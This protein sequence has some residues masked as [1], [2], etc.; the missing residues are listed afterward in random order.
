MAEVE[1]AQ[2]VR[3]AA[4][5]SGVW[6]TRN[7]V[8]ALQ[9]KAGRLV[10]YGL[11]NESAAQNKRMKSADDIGI[12]PVLIT[13]AHV[14]QTL[15]QFV[16]VEAK[17]SGWRYSGADREPAQLAWAKHVERLGGRALIVTS[18]E[19]WQRAGI[20]GHRP[21]QLPAPSVS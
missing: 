4:D 8:G 21:C 7:N 11:A 20:V 14:G 9:D 13:P 1:V 3:L 16:S 2:R 10:R 18:A 17:R 5:A 12:C 6:L 15:G 19:D